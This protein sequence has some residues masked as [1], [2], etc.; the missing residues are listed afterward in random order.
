MASSNPIIV[1]GGVIA[2]GTFTLGETTYVTNVS[3]AT[4]G[5][6]GVK[7]STD[8]VSAV[9]YTSFPNSAGT[10]NALTNLNETVRIQGG[11]VIAGAGT[12]S[13]Q[14]GP[15]AAA[16]T[17]DS[18]AIGRTA[19]VTSATQTIVIGSTA[20]NGGNQGVVIG[21][22]AAFTNCGGVVIGHSAGGTGN[23]GG[24]L[25]LAV[26]STASATCAT[27][28]GGTAVALG[29]GAVAVGEC[30][31]IG[32]NASSNANSAGGAGSVVIGTS[33]AS[34]KAN[35]FNVAIGY[36][37]TVT[38][39]N[40]VAIGSGATITAAAAQTYSIVI[41]A[42]TTITST[43]SIT[44]GGGGVDLGANIMQLGAASTPI[45]TWVLGAGDTIAAPAAKTIRFTNASGTDNAAGNVTHI[46]ALSSG[47]ATPGRY[48]IQVGLQVAGSSSTLQTATTA[49]SI[50]STTASARPLLQVATGTMQFG[51]SPTATAAIEID[52]AT[53]IYSGIGVAVRSGSRAVF[54]WNDGASPGTGVFSNH[55]YSLY[56]NGVVIMALAPA[57][58]VTH[59]VNTANTGA[60]T[61]SGYSL[62]GSD[63][64]TMVNW[65]GT[66]NTSGTPT[67]F[68]LAITNTAS[69]AASLLLNLLAGAGG[70]TSMFSVK[71][72]GDV[73]TPGQLLSSSNIQAGAASAIYWTSQ[74]VLRSPANAQINFLNQAET[75]GV[76]FDIA[77]DAILKLRVRAQ[78]AYA[79]LDVLGLKA[80]GAAGASFGPGL[81]T[82][83]TVVNGIVTAAS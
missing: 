9:V 54:V 20:S 43:Q 32:G 62:T 42:G 53:A 8:A 34:N 76:G 56:A 19:T 51:T 10:Y 74:T 72:N 61:S 5:T 38:Q 52:T 25:V 79:T 14:I 29:P 23:A 66:W 27:A 81:P 16:G 3:P 1:G 21:F 17:T 64:T 59:T 15:A 46:A 83:L 67:A 7:V 82:S 55:T 37:A 31:V 6:Y 73:T 48:I 57:G 71:I 13:T 22:A 41:G 47:N 35:G 49:L 39:T 58:L 26:G 69:N 40:A 75:A 80:S 63:A 60:W 68:K 36:T 70:V 18:I 65:A 50:T 77:T 4:I 2:G 11:A 33:A 28:G 45:V 30:V 12:N 44:I 78:N 24:A